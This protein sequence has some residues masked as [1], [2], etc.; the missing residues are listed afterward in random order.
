MSRAFVKDDAQQD[1]VVVPPRAPLPPGVPNYVTGR[2]LKRLRA[3]QAG[4]EAERSRLLAAPMDEAERQRQLTA[5]AGRLDALTERIASAKVLDLRMQPQDEVRF[6]AT[7]TLRSAAGEE[8]RFQIVGVDEADAAEGRVAFIAPLA[9][10]VIGRHVGE[11]VTLRTPR[12]EERLEVVAIA[13][14]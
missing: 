3:E 9:R 8:R 4:L 11:T 10:A 7:V 12:G 6:G 2:G 14:A 1:P 13:Y 5:L